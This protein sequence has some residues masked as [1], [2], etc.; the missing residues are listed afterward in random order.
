M[1][2]DRDKFRGALMRQG[3][4]REGKGRR[5]DE[6]GGDKRRKLGDDN[7]KGAGSLEQTEGKKGEERKRNRIERRSLI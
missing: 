1:G 5:Y 7:Y 3:R 6:R 2:R 4:G